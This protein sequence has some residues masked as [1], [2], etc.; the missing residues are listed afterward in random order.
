MGRK[1]MNLWRVLFAFAAI[2]NLAVGGAM[3]AAPARAAEGLGIS[4]AAGP[5]AIAMCGMLIAVFGVGYAM[6]AAQPAQNRGIVWIGLIGKIGAATLGA[7]Q[8]VA[9]IIPVST[10]ALGMGDL[11]F[12]AAFAAFLWLGPRPG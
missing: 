10:F 11:A 4:G 12:A 6:V 2:W 3:L 1:T 8:Y 5:F 9:G 7:L